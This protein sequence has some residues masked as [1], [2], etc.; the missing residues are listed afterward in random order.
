M[1]HTTLLNLT[2]GDLILLYFV[3][4]LLGIVVSL[5]FGLVAATIKV[6]FL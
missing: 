2:G 6:L 5:V 1:L 4:S 3:T